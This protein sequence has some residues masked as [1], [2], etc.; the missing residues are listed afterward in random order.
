MT[1]NNEFKKFKNARNNNLNQLKN[2]LLDK[3]CNKSQAIGAS[4]HY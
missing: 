4:R 3:L 2:I 1:H